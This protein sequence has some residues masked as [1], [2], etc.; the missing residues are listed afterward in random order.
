MK[1]NLQMREEDREAGCNGSKWFIPVMRWS[2]TP[3]MRRQSM[4]CETFFIYAINTYR[5]LSRLFIVGG[6]ELKSS[7]GTTQG[8]PVSMAIYAVCLRP[9]ITSLHSASFA[10]QC[11]FADNYLRQR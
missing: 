1:S 4:L 3:V 11:W 6:K 7:E 8:D 5:V 2:I 10:E 9:F